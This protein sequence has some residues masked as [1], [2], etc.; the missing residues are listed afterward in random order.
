T[1]V[2]SIAG[3]RL[4]RLKASPHLEG[5]RARCIEVLLL[6]DPVD[7]FWVVPSQGFDGKPF[8]SVTQGAADLT[9]IPRLDAVTSAAAAEIAGPVKNF[10]AFL[11]ATLGEAV[12]EVRAS[13]RLTH[14]AGCL[15]AADKGPDRAVE[16]L[17]AG[18]GKLASPAK[19]VLEVNPQHELIKALAPRGQ[20]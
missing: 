14:S 8:R 2:Y 10:L 11:K 17:L 5:F 16:R 19:P 1:A 7:T 15:V 13:E 4:S 9:L 20:R 18:A 3:D 6:P 12:A